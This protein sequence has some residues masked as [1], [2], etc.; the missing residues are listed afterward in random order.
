MTPRL[1][2]IAA[3]LHV[4]PAAAA[5]AAVIEEK[6]LTVGRLAPAHIAQSAG[7]EKIGGGLRYW[8]QDVVQRI[9]AVRLP[10]PAIAAVGAGQRTVLQ[11]LDG[12]IVDDVEVGRGRRLALRDGRKD[13]IDRLAQLNCFAQDLLRAHGM[14]PGKGPQCTR[15][16]GGD[17][18]RLL[19]ETDEV[20]KRLEVVFAPLRIVAAADS[21]G[22][23]KA[24]ISA[25]KIEF[26]ASGALFL[27]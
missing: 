26:P 7:G 19:G 18:S 3:G 15:L 11:R 9:L 14:L 8:P 23:V 21:V 1:L 6:P 10:L 5:I 4:A 27:H 17:G 20:G 2:A 12:K 16:S 22:Q 24:E 25:R 13:A